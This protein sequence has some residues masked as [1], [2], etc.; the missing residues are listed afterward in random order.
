MTATVE[1]SE[2]PTEQAEMLTQLMTKRP[3]APAAGAAAP[4]ATDQFSYDVTLRDGQRTRTLHWTEAEVP[5]EVKP[6]LASLTV[7]AKPAPPA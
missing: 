2:L 3:D 7:R 5:D 1:A 6:V 4:G